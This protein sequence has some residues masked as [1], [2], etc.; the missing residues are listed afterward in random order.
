[1][2]S[3][4]FA[5]RLGPGLGWARCTRPRLSSLGSPSVTAIHACTWSLAISTWLHLAAATQLR[6]RRT[7]SALASLGHAR[8]M[9][10]ACPDLDEGA[11]PLSVALSKTPPYPRPPPKTRPKG[12]S[13]PKGGGGDDAQGVS[14]PKQERSMQD[15]RR[16]GTCKRRESNGARFVHVK[17]GGA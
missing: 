8:R 16:G 14:S 13:S 3:M 6:S 1:M 4:T 5:C 15:K 9:R 17:D 10:Q 2:G 12:V 7:C 11:I